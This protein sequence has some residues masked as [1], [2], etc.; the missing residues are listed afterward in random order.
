MNYDDPNE[1]GRDLVKIE[2]RLADAY[3]KEREARF[4][5]SSY[6]PGIKFDKAWAQMA[7][8]VYDLKAN[9]EDWI[10]A[11]FTKPGIMPFPNQM[12]GDKAKQN[13]LQMEEAILATPD[14]NLFTHSFYVEC[15]T[16]KVGLSIHEVF[17]NDSVDLRAW[18][19]VV[20]CPEPILPHI[21]KKY[22]KIAVSQL[23]A[24]KALQIY[25]IKNHYDRA[26]RIIPKDV[27]TEFT[28]AHHEV[29]TAFTPAVGR[30][31]WS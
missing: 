28:R 12:F 25:L 16:K 20:F 18:Y 24:D 6:K 9:P 8:V 30:T 7:E 4:P 17:L 11:Q 22:K 21:S 27:S 31:H 10:K 15:L 2:M 5:A 14:Q 26:I 3:I 29:S 19:R 13:Y 1:K 23:N